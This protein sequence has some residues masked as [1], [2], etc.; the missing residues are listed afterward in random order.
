MESEL[1]E[2]MARLR[3]YGYTGLDELEHERTPNRSASMRSRTGT[4][5]GYAWRCEPK[6]EPLVSP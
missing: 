1:D 2:V 4:A 5:I 3:R 6:A